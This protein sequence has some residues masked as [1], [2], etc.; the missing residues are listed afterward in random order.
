MTEEEAGATG[1]VTGGSPA[2]GPNSSRRR[3]SRCGCPTRPLASCSR[4]G[5]SRVGEAVAHGRGAPRDAAAHGRDAGLWMRRRTG[6]MRRTGEKPHS[7]C[8]SSLVRFTAHNGSW[9]LGPSGHNS[10]LI[11]KS[12]MSARALAWS[13]LFPLVF[14][15][16]PSKL[17]QT[18]FVTCMTS[19]LW[20]TAKS[21]Q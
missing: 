12:F 16:V 2:R 8:L 6:E 3:Q 18:F 5:E 19:M 15:S 11:S 17:P 21:F 20:R 1:V 4:M 13:L 14:K 10:G 7:F 9:A